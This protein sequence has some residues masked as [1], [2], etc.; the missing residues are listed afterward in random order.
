MHIAGAIPAGI[1]VAFQFTPIIRHKFMLFHRING[2]LIM[3]LILMSNAGCAILLRRPMGTDIPWQTVVTILIIFTTF[4]GA[5]AIWNIKR[6]QIDQHRAWMLRCMFTLG[7]AVTGRVIGLSGAYFMTRLGGWY[8]VWPCDMIDFTNRQFGITDVLETRYP[9]CLTSNGT[10]NGQVVVQAALN[11]TAP[12]ETGAAY[13]LLAGPAVWLAL[14]LHVVG[15]E[16]YLHLTPRE[17]M[18]LRQVS[19]EK[20]VAAGFRNPGYSGTSVER[21][22]DAEKW[23]PEHRFADSEKA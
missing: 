23:Q 5:M 17:A 3:L 19:Y 16:M 22:G 2:Y 20:Q 18:R 6:L 21:W 15:L 7:V 10:L 8:S 11:A 4:S 9:Q 13:A 12:E 14:I 1:L